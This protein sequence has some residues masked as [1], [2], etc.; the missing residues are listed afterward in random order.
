MPEG[1]ATLGFPGE[2]R[3]P[4]NG[5][6]FTIVKFSSEQDNNFRVVSETIAALI[7]HVL[8]RR[9]YQGIYLRSLM[10]C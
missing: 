4:L 3:V 6:H 9:E 10:V 5:N 2:I 1:S 7:R 8:V